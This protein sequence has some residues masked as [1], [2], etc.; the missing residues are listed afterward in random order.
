MSDSA[1]SAELT[2]RGVCVILTT[3]PRQSSSRENLWASRIR[4]LSCLIVVSKCVG[5]LWGRC[6]NDVIF[7]Y[8]SSPM[9]GAQS[10]LRQDKSLPL[11][12][13]SRPLTQ[14]EYA[15]TCS[16]F[17]PCS[18]LQHWCWSAISTPY[19]S[20]SFILCSQCHQH[21]CWGA[22]STPYWSNHFILSSQCLQHWCWGAMSTPYWSNLFILGSQ[23]HQH[24][25]WGAIS[26][27][28]WSDS[29]ILSSQCHQHWCWGAISTPYW[30]N[31]F[32]LSSQCLQHWCWG[33]I[34]TPYWSDS[35]ILRCTG[36][37]VLWAPLTGEIPLFSFFFFL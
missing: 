4:W 20:D 17:K 13:S 29:F 30:S 25:C 7:A 23:C 11:V 34:N 1:N 31:P 3:I 32:I 24:W 18:C 21:W 36:V 6:S 14:G 8:S 33:A 16:Y 5:Q 9:S 15:M 35:F 37:G 22:M 26:T 12:P 10:L 28:Y 27:P 2:T 19:W